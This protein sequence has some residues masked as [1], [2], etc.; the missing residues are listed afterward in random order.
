[1]TV[2]CTVASLASGKPNAHLRWS[3]RTV[4]G[5]SPE[6]CADANRSLMGERPQPF[7]CVSVSTGSGRLNLQEAFLRSDLADSAEA[8]PLDRNAAKATRSGPVR[9][10]P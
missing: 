3:L 6:S 5:V 2:G 10:A 9:S 1:M 4:A 8:E 7:H